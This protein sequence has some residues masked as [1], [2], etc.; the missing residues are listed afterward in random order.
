M[1]TLHKCEHLARVPTLRTE[2]NSLFEPLPYKYWLQAYKY[3][4]SIMCQISIFTSPADFSFH[5]SFG[6]V[7]LS[8]NN[9][10]FYLYV[11]TYLRY[12]EFE[13]NLKTAPSFVWENNY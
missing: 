6:T 4:T 2:Q 13:E 7:S 9:I 12:Q 11:H 5:V 10:R 1:L 3:S 8:F